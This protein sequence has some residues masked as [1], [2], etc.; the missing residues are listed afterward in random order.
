[1]L[2][3][4]IV[5]SKRM[6][7]DVMRRNLPSN[8]FVQVALV[9]SLEVRLRTITECSSKLQT[10]LQELKIAVGILGLPPMPVQSLKSTLSRCNRFCARTLDVTIA[11]KIVIGDVLQDS[12][13]QQLIQWAIIILGLTVEKVQK[14]KKLTLNSCLCCLALAEHI[15]NLCICS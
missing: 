13:L 5:N 6:L 15:D 4:G 12:T 14:D 3:K 1:M 9:D 7:F 10:Y 11:T 8:S 2:M